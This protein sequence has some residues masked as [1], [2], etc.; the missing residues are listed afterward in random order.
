MTFASIYF[1][2]PVQR[3]NIWKISGFEKMTFSES[4]KSQIKK[5]KIAIFSFIPIQIS[6]KFIEYIPLITGALNELLCLKNAGTQIS[7]FFTSYE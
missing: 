5:L 3:T 7:L 2:K 6:H 1:I 4:T